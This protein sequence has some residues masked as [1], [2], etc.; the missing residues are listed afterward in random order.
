ME[1]NGVIMHPKFFE[2]LWDAEAATKQALKKKKIDPK[3]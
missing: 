2:S 1:A 3:N